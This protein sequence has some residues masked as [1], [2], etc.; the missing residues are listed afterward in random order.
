M[1][2]TLFSL[3]SIMFHFCD[4]FSALDALTRLRSV[5]CIVHR[6]PRWEWRNVGSKKNGTNVTARLLYSLCTLPPLINICF[7]SHQ[8]CRQWLVMWFFFFSVFIAMPLFAPSWGQSKHTHSHFVGASSK[9]L[10]RFRGWKSIFA[11]DL[12]PK[13]AAEKQREKL[14]R[15]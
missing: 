1:R 5:S 4:C 6:R 12:S 15:W 11:C 10:A 3:H 7:E 2:I 8:L 9:K 13:R 14:L